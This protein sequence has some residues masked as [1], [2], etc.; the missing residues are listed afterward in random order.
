NSHQGIFRIFGPK[1]YNVFD[2][3]LDT[4]ESHYT[5]SAR[6]FHFSIFPAATFA[7]GNRALQ[8]YLDDDIAG[9]WTALTALGEYNKEE[10]G[11]I[12]LWDL[13][14]VIKFRTGSTILIPCSLVRYSFVKIVPRET[15]YCL[16]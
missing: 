12:I 7:L 1:L 3:V 9:G 14:R 16:T 4:Y 11:H 10:G 5:G 15:R 6:P 13:N 8:P 2:R